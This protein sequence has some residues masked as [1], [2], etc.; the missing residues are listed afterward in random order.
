M[1]I[2]E[3]APIGIV[4]GGAMGRGIAAVAAAEHPVLIY[5]ADSAAAEKAVETAQ[6]SLARRAA[7]GKLANADSAIARLRPAES[8]KELADCAVVI[9]AVVENEEVKREVFSRLESACAPAAILASN[10]SSLSIAR[11]AAGLRHPERVGG[12]HFFNPPTAMK[13]VEIVRAQTTSAEVAAALRDLAA[14]WGKTPIIV[15]NTPG[16]VANR[17]ARPFYGEALRMLEEGIADVRCIDDCL[18]AAGFPLGPFQLMDLIG[19]DVNLA[20]SESVFR[21]LYYDPRFRPSPLQREMVDANLLGR[22][23]GMGFYDYKTDPP[24]PRD[25]G[26]KTPCLAA[27]N[28]KPEEITVYGHAKDF[29]EGRQFAAMIAALA[30]KRGI[31]VKQAPPFES[32]DGKVCGVRCHSALLINGGGKTASA[33]GVEIWTDDLQNN[34]GQE[35]F[36]FWSE[37]NSGLALLDFAG[38]RVDDVVYPV[39]VDRFADAGAIAVAPGPPKTAAAAAADAACLLHAVGVK[40][41]YRIADAPGLI[42][43]RTIAALVNCVADAAYFRVAGE[44][45]INAAL[46]AGFN[47]PDCVVR[48]DHKIGFS[49][50]TGTIRGLFEFYGEERYRPSPRRAALID[51]EK[52]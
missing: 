38:R 39:A 3:N 32:D 15:A 27:D 40:R 2:A 14:S 33:S 19:N 50:L 24:T 22:K 35:R 36:K 31:K 37:D 28:N 25:F 16:F 49:H 5:D 10:T 26:F 21:G 43:L 47:F 18:T 51:G 13:L 45:E 29:A 34:A 52:Q 17:V 42:I 41:V 1:K 7:K 6:A 23:T 30:G 8:I 12:M 48:W 46:R 20:T 44:D 9:E 4:G 11:L